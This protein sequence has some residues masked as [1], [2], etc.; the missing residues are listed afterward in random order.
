M[1]ILL[2]PQPA[3]EART[4]QLLSQSI[5]RQTI[6]RKAKVEEASNGYRGRAKLFLLFDEIGA[7]NEAD[8]AFVSEGG[9]KLEHFG[10]DGLDKPLE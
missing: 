3:N 9:E 4:S 7:P 10:G 6:L 2:L 1:L 5:S 8:G